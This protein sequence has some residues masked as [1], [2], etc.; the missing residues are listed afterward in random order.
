MH[1]SNKSV[2]SEIIYHEVFTALSSTL[3]RSIYGYQISGSDDPFL[4]EAI[5]LVRN[6]SDAIM[7]TNFLVN[8]FPS[9]RYIPSWFPGTGWK[10]TACAWRKQKERAMFSLFNKTKEAIATGN[11][12][13]SM[14]ASSL[15]NA[16]SHGLSP[17][18]VDDYLNYAGITVYL[19]GAETTSNVFLIFAIAMMLYP[20]T[21]RKAQM[22]IDGL[23]GDSRLPAMEDKHRLPYTNR[24][25]Q[26][27]LR[28]CPVGPTGKCVP[29]AAT[30]DDIYRGFRIPKGAI[31]FANIW[32][33]SRSEKIYEEPE[34]FNPDRFL[35]PL[36]PPCPVFGF[37]R[38]ECPGSH[39]AE[40]SMFIMIASILAVFN[41]EIPRN[42]QGEKVI[43]KLACKNTLIYHPE[44][45]QLKLQPRSDRHTH[46]VYTE[47]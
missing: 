47:A 15:V 41:V 35:D 17:E 11:Y 24:L 29:H 37:G 1:L 2:S 9:L 10:Q 19:G 7:P 20:E 22:E 31:V 12:E 34:E 5:E 46:L 36:V 32:A 44:E 30:N 33:M 13:P 40:S 4:K 43:P 38:R 26:E 42:A 3:L 6:L 45:F 18:E 25:I 28:W 14:I 39:F 23:I 21:Q 8:V 27:L 16:Q